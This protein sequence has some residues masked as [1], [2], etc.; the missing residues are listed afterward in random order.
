[1]IQGELVDTA[2]PELKRERLTRRYLY[3]G[4]GLLI[5]I[6]TTGAVSRLRPA[7]PSV[8]RATIWTDTVKRGPMLLAVRGLGMLEPENTVVI[9]A[10]TDAR[11][12]RRYLLPGTPV[13]ASTIILDL[14]DPQLQQ[15][16]LDAEYQLKGA[17]ASYERTKAQLQNQLMDKRAQAAQVS[18]QFQTAKLSAES[19]EKLAASGRSP[20]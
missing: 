17:E 14:S 7:A 3:A 13:K 16:S 2:C 18:S 8:D 19:N 9:P 5:A 20:T 4:L 11:V 6:G 15:E 10:A 12:E 1:M